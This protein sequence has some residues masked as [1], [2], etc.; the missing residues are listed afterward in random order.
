V[1]DAVHEGK[2]RIDAARQ[3][4]LK[5]GNS[6]LFPGFGF[7]PHHSLSFSILHMICY[8]ADAHSGRSTV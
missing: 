5:L 7:I 8:G 1:D 2:S 3:L 6:N 4:Q